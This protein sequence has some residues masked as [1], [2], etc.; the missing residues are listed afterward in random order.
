MWPAR[1][2]EALVEA[3]PWFIGFFILLVFLL[4]AV[5][6]REVTDEQ[7]AEFAA[8]RGWSYRR[9]D[10]ALVRGWTGPPFPGRGDATSVMS[11]TVDGQQFTSFE[12]TWVEG[13]GDDAVTRR[14]VVAAIALPASLPLLWITPQT[15]AHQLTNTLGAGDITFESSQFN[16]AFA[17][18]ADSD[19]YAY[20]VVGQLVMAHLMDTPAGANR[21]R[22]E[23]NHALTW[24]DGPYDPDRAAALA[25]GLAGF[26]NRIPRF[27]Y[28]QF[29]T[30]SATGYAGSVSGLRPEATG[31]D[32]LRTG[33]ILVWGAVWL[34]ISVPMTFLGWTFRGEVTGPSS[35]FWLFPA[36]FVL[37]GVLVVG[38]ALVKLVRGGFAI[39]ANQRRRRLAA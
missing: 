19:R 15:V 13:S 4:R 27:V 7:L 30:G 36:A 22:I 38:S 24:T 33:F 14:C 32:L 2:E 39:W 26:V 29:A 12:L 28:D 8:S 11:G 3:W 1:R 21:I 23:G 18:T 17:V 6:R 9:A 25:A 37:V 5:P 16:D 31:A 34:G 20:A 10:P 35:W